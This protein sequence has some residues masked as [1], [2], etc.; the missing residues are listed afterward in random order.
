MSTQ[1]DGSFT[2]DITPTWEEA[3]RMCLMI[4]ENTKS[5]D[6][7][8]DAEQELFRMGRLLDHFI[9]ERQSLAQVQEEEK[10]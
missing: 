5:I 7:R 9:A 8:R 3:V 4:I 6:G 10:A 2:V 1:E